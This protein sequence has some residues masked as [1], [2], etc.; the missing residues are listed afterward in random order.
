MNKFNFFLTFIISIFI[1]AC[2]SDKQDSIIDS[3]NS[4]SNLTDLES[5]NS[6]TDGSLAKSIIGKPV[7]VMTRN[8]YIGTDV[9]DGDFPA[10]TLTWSVAVVSGSSWDTGATSSS[11]L[12]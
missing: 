7:R 6:E 12:A 2:S 1:F 10:E 8:L 5:F 11:L 3:N 4:E 9:D